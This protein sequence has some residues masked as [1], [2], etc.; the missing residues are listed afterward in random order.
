MNSR[1]AKARLV[2][3]KLIINRHRY[4]YHVKNRPEISDAV[5]DSLQHELYAIEK[6]FPELLTPDSPS[7]RVS[8]KPLDKF[9][10]I[11][12]S[13]RVLSLE[14]YF[15]F[16]EVR[17]WYERTIRLTGE[18]NIELTVEPK[19]D[20]LALI[21]RYKNGLLQKGIT[22]GDGSVGEDVTQNIKTIQSIP[23]T[24]DYQEDLEIRG[25]VV[26]HKKDFVRINAKGE[27]A[28]PRNL[29]AGSIRQLDPKV[30]AS[31][32]LT[33]YAYEIRSTIP[34][35]PSLVRKGR[36][37]RVGM[38][39]HAD[40]LHFLTQLGFRVDQH[41]GVYPDVSGVQKYL[42]LWEKR[43]REL[44]FNTD[45]AVINV[46]DKLLHAKL[47]VVGKAPRFR[48]AYKYA[49]EERTSVVEGIIV[50]VG[51]LGTLTPVAKLQ[52]VEVAGTTVSRA[53]LHNEDQ[54]QRLDVRVGDTVVVRKA[55]DIIPEV[56]KVLKDLR[57][58]GARAFTMPA[59]CPVCGAAVV[60]GTGEVATRCSN[61]NCYAVQREKLIHFVSRKGFDIDGLG[62][63]IV[64]Q[65]IE[66]GL[67][68][69]AADFF[70][71]TVGD[72]EPLEKFAEKKSVNLVAA[73]AHS[74]KILL[75]KF[76][77]ALGIPHIG[78]EM[79]D[80]LSL[81]LNATKPADLLKDNLLQSAEKLNAIEGFGDIVAE[82]VAGYFFDKR[83]QK[84]L[85]DLTAA[86][87]RLELPPVKK[88]NPA[89][90]GKTFVFTGTLESMSRDEAKAL[91]KSLG[92]KVSESVSRETDYVVAGEEP[93]SKYE[94]AKKLG[95]KLIGEQEFSVFLRKK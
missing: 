75:N 66:N 6:Q 79:A 9:D 88:T 90:S 71:L 41:C 53:T 10:K 68:R 60:R 73:L 13:S 94:K 64:G 89:V 65:L 44:A 42:T 34:P 33:F 21:L 37:L 84:L 26:I 31:R 82:S 67:V 56:V 7:Q 49:A 52:P 83:N 29:A 92:G 3:L 15:S 27:F 86:G 25:E 18:Q 35:A 4:A 39:T 32:K 57:P 69:D 58:S 16:A 47:G 22:R 51:R 59:K 1:E 95:V 45:G 11:R 14:D 17:E 5:Y 8:G 20:G 93:G 40:E 2:K 62:E 19:L 81:R 50:Q 77:Y 80:E 76:I 23:L 30:T 46:N 87:V 63:K 91:V 54:I 55:G 78:E 36:D 70:E 72:L 61:K 48:V 24:I 85:A 38:V 12:H 28:N 43:R 74:K